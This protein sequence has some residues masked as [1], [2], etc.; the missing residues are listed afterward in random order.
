MPTLSSEGHQGM[1][2]LGIALGLAWA[3]SCLLAFLAGAYVAP[4]CFR[5][6]PGYRG[7]CQWGKGEM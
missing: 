1:I 3:A 6:R 4:E 5:A 7:P 2:L